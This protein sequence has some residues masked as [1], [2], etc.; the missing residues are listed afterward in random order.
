MITDGLFTSC[1]FD[2]PL[3]STSPAYFYL[4]D[5]QNEFTFNKLYGEC[6]KPF[7]VSHADEL[8]SLFK[9][10]PLVGSQGLNKEDSEFS[11]VMVNIWT[12]F[13]SSE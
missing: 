8:I 13:A 12:K 5:Y 6:A 1:L 11:K 3:K 2:I 9:I 10:G 7:G 4:F